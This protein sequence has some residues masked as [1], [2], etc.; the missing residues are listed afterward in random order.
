MNE[1]IK[2]QDEKTATVKTENAANAFNTDR[3]SRQCTY[4]CQEGAS[5]CHGVPVD[6]GTTFTQR[7]FKHSR[8]YGTSDYGTSVYATVS[9][10]Y[11][12][13][14]TR[15]EST[16]QPLIGSGDSVSS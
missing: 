9:H 11:K 14:G 7:H 6:T 1:R 3:E 2:I 10:G 15:W 8:D 5:T 4:C 13:V 16:W 12:I